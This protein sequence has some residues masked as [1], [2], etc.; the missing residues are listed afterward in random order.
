MKSLH[1]VFILLVVF[2]LSACGTSTPVRTDVEN[3]QPS[4]A[5]NPDNTKQEMVETT[6]Q[7]ETTAEAKNETTAQAKPETTAEPTPDTAASETTDNQAAE[8]PQQPQ[9]ENAAPR[10]DK[11]EAADDDEEIPANFISCE[12]KIEH[13]DSLYQAQAIG[14]TL[15]EARDNALEEA[16]ALPCANA[17]EGNESEEDTDAKLESC[18][19]S[20]SVNTI[21]VAAACHQNGKSIYT[22][23][24]WNENGDAAPTNGAE[25]PDTVK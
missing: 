8:I 10:N 7:H 5:V 16:C 3:V 2:L 25:T 4:P 19:E 9:A 20:C 6:P 13:D 17:L 18:T 22:E 12:I 1:T 14:P 15:E 24:A 11:P 23:G 21:V